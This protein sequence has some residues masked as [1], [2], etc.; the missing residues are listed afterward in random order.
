MLNVG[1]HAFNE[2]FNLNAFIEYSVYVSEGA[3]PFHKAQ[4]ELAEEMR[5]YGG[6]CCS[7]YSN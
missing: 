1:R 7:T 5:M 6:G 4:G 2:E 3:V